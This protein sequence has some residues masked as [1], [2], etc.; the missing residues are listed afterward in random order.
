MYVYFSDK[1]NR[2]AQQVQ[3]R[4]TSV[5]M[6][7]PS[8]SEADAI[9]IL[10]ELIK[11]HRIA[12]DDILALPEIKNRG[13]SPMAICHFLEQHGLVKKTLDTKR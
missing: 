5:A 9:A 6:A 7:R 10:V 3:Q 8:I 12:L 13:L 1:E 11:H 4:A 2:Y